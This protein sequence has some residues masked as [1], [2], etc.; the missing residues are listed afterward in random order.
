MELHGGR[1][2]SE[3]VIRYV[4]EAAPAVLSLIT[5]LLM[6]FAGPMPSCATRFGLLAKSEN[7]FRVAY[8]RG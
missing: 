3:I 1:G 2:I 4:F 7:F 6:I 5:S 8:R